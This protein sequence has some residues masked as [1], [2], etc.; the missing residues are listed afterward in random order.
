MRKTEIAEWIGRKQNKNAIIALEP[1]VIIIANWWLHEIETNDSSNYRSEEIRRIIASRVMW[2]VARNAYGLDIVIPSEN[3]QIL[4][5][6]LRWNHRD[7]NDERTFCY[8]SKFPP[9][10]AQPSLTISLICK[11]TQ[12]FPLNFFFCIFTFRL[13]HTPPLLPSPYRPPM[14]RNH[15]ELFT[16]L[17]HIF[18]LVFC[19]EKLTSMNHLRQKIDLVMNE[20]IANKQ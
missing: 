4:W 7:N 14:K 12:V 8:S 1:L 15:F 2:N 18:P 13:F 5:F 10:P 17:F 11:F 9:T 19:N 6:L 16:Q 3:H 20:T